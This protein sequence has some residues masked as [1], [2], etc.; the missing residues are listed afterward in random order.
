MTT[1][2]LNSYE[3][4]HGSIFLLALKLFMIIFFSDL[5]YL[6]VDILLLNTLQA[7]YYY[8]LI[9]I[10]SFFHIFKSLAQIALIFMVVF[11]WLYHKYHI[12]YGQKKLY[13]HKGF[14]HTKEH[15]SDLRNVRDVLMEQK[16]LGKLFHYGDIILTISASGGYVEKVV[17]KKIQSP[18]LYIDY[19]ENCGNAAY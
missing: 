9:L 6:L 19:F 1:R 4:I 12:D 15:M 18:D 14:L 2:S 17:L 13:E 7:D 3:S 16:F 10:M 8:H 5:F 11:H